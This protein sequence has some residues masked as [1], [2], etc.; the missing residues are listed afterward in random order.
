ME[1]M[2]IK[3]LTVESLKTALNKILT[4]KYKQNEQS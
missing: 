4:L 3:P 2:I 1:N